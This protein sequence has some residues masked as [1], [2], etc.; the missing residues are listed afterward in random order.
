MYKVK[1]YAKWNR[2]FARTFPF[3][4]GIKNRYNFNR[5]ITKSKTPYI[6]SI[7]WEI[8]RGSIAPETPRSNNPRVFALEIAIHHFPRVS[9]PLPSLRSW[10]VHSS[11]AR[12]PPGSNANFIAGDVELTESLSWI[13]IISGVAL[14]RLFPWWGEGRCKR[15]S[16]YLHIGIMADRCPL[17]PSVYPPWM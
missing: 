1:I 7:F 16:R 12:N 2:S 10:P 14:A 9:V 5:N 11:T 8:K 17:C 4:V 3:A 6:F 15:V 13:L